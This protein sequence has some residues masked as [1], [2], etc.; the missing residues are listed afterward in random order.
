MRESA[1]A[2]RAGSIRIGRNGTRIADGPGARCLL[3]RR[4]SSSGRTPGLGNFADLALTGGEDTEQRCDQPTRGEP[5]R[6]IDHATVAEVIGE[7]AQDCR[8]IASLYWKISAGKMSA[9]VR[10]R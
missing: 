3:S 7:T 9:D 10:G 2:Q 5:S 4:R 8:A 6:A 1:E